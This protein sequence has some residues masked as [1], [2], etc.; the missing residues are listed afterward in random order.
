MTEAAPHLKTWPAAAKDLAAR[1][2]RRER[3]RAILFPL[4]AGLA[5]GAGAAWAWR[6][7]GGA[8]DASMAAALLVP[9]LVGLFVGLRAAARVTPTA[10]SDAAWALDRL[11]SARGRGL[12]AA[13]VSGAA[14]AEAAWGGPPLVPPATRLLAP[15]GLVAALAAAVLAATPFVAAPGARAHR[16]PR[17]VGDPT[18]AAAAGATESG[19]L[20]ATAASAGRSAA[21]ARK[22][23]EALGIPA[24]T[25]VGAAELKDRLKDPAALAAAKAAA[26]EGSEA[27]A[28]LGSDGAAAASAL[29][30]ALAEGSAESADALRREAAT[31]RAGAGAPRVPPSRRDLVTRYL[32]ARLAAS[33]GGTTR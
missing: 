8:V 1:V 23:R 12:V 32:T 13:T 27:A 15:G 30:R 10:P 28:A 16:T 24:G 19:R 26:P 4:A 2:T 31:V 3:V 14:G 18:P 29:A 17:G 22:V 6:L 9:A 33:T 20:D 21:T 11:A 7:A 25:P 5:V